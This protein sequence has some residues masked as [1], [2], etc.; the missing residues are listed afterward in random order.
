VI[1]TIDNLDGL[2]AVDYTACLDASSPLT[3]KRA[4]NAPSICAGLLALHGM[5][6]P[7]RRGRVIIAADNGTLVFTGYIATEAVLE[8]AGAGLAGP[9]YRTAFN[10]VSDEWLLDKQTVP[11]SGAGL[12]QDGGVVLK[13]LTDRVGSGLLATTAVADGRAVGIFEPAQGQSWSANAATIAGT[14][15]AA[16]RALDGAVALVPA[17]AV[18]H[19]F[20]DGDGTLQIAALQSA[21]IKELANDV[22]VSGAIEP[23]AYVS[24]VFEG[25]GATTVFTLTQEPFIPT[26]TNGSAYLLND[27]FNTGAFN[28]Q[29]W[30]VTNAGAYLGFGANGL[31]MTGGNGLDGQTTLVAIDAIEL[32]GTLLI[33]AGSLLLA[34]ACD[35]VLC[36]LY[37]GPVS[38]TSCFAGYNVRQSGGLTIA[39]P[40]LNGVEVGTSYTVVT[41]HRYTLRIRLHSAEVQRVLQSYYAMVDGVVESFGGGLTASAIQVVFELVDLGVSSNTPATVLYDSANAGPIVSSPAS[42]TFAAVDS[43]QMF[44]SMGYCRV[45]QTGSAW[46]TSKLP[47]GEVLT[48][49]IGAAG[50]GVDCSVSVAGAVTFYAGRIPAAGEIVTVTYRDRQRA[51]ARLEDTASIAREAAGDAPGIA[52]WLG[53]V[54]QPVARSTVDCEQSALAILS[55]SSSRAAAIAGTYVALNPQRAADIWPGDVLALTTNGLTTIVVVRGVAITN[56]AASPE[57]LTYRIAFANDWAEGLGLTL[58]ETVAS[59]ALL[60][61]TALQGPASVLANLQQMTIVSVSGTAIQIDAGVAAPAGGGFEVRRRDGDF[62]P[63]VDQDLVLRTPVRGFS[64]PRVAQAEQYFVRMYDGSSPPVYSRFSSAVFTDVPVA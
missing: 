59:D 10:A 64:I 20:S 39:T 27:S 53:H 56:E 44:G 48:R 24:E 4:L 61:Q 14:T 38:R 22:T 49:L 17:G 3:I 32:G 62:G 6:I 45:T 8:Y 37:E 21:A 41:G 31:S 50:E 12:A 36:G 40:F 54:L 63:F 46:V 2:G 9:V 28:P 51:V 60:P 25:D 52:A 15:Y 18:T 13:T 26:R 1:L 57:L 34:E 19:A 35:G 55:F 47:S 30:T 58:S 23:A 33:E 16:Y 42:C 29:V 43:V 5:A 11:F 7:T